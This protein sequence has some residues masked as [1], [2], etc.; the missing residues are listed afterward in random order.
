MET[1][2]SEAHGGILSWCSC[3]CC[4]CRCCCIVF[5]VDEKRNL[6]W[7]PWV[8][9]AACLEAVRAE[10]RSGFQR[11]RC[12]RMLSG[13]RRVIR[14]N[15]TSCLYVYDALLKCAYVVSPLPLS[16]RSSS[17]P[18]PPPLPPAPY[19]L[20]HPYQ[21]HTTN[22]QKDYIN[23]ETSKI[24]EKNKSTANVKTQRQ[25]TTTT[26][27]NINP[28]QTQATAKQASPHLLGQGVSIGSVWLV[29][30]VTLVA[31]E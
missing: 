30:G 17:P 7:L 28:K 19:R 10:A 25:H 1:L 12:F 9:V 8:V 15:T 22:P 18:L 21:H 3:P 13:M 31:V 27:N 23:T 26:T 6:V 4:C 14:H 2:L 16:S 5:C 20:H 11:C 24:P 29:A